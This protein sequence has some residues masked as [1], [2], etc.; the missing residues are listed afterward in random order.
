LAAGVTTAERAARIE[1]FRAAPTRVAELAPA[2]AAVRGDQ[3][4]DGWSEREIVAHLVRVDREVFQVRLRDLTGPSEPHWSW[5]EPGAEPGRATL[6]TLVT[7]FAAIREVTIAH[8][9]GLDDAGWARSGVHATYGRL[10]VA[11]LLGIAI[12]HDA[13][14]IAELERRAG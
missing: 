2:A 5:V 3:A 8:L 1:R 7:R 13:D 14:H 6:D 10:D 4:P 11:A 12:D 9:A